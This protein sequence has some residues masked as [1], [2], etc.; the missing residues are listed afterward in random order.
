MGQTH[1]NKRLQQLMLW[2]AFVLAILVV[3]RLWLLSTSEDDDARQAVL[4]EAGVVLLPEPRELP[5]VS[6]VSTEEQ[7]LQ[8]HQ[9]PARWHLVFFGY[10][11]C[12]DICPTTLAEL[13]MLYRALPE[14]IR[15]QWQVLMVSVDP[16]RDSPQHLRDYLN[17]FEQSFKGVTGEL[18][19][20]QSLSQAL[21]IP[22][23]PGDSSRPDYTVDHSGNLAII[24]PDGRQHGFVRAP[25]K[26][27]ALS[28]ALPLLLE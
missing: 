5:P 9:L 10:T 28:E 12:P 21:A 18:A 15:K 4:R 16:Q 13:R 7:P 11:Y 14:P 25:L 19:A 27:S 3:A 26:V 24:G 1:T 8:M 20:I 6:L 23:I 22:F 2:L 17:F